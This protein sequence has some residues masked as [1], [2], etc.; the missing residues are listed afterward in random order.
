[1]KTHQF[2]EITTSVEKFSHDGRGIARINGKTTFIQGALP[3]ETVVFKYTRRKRGF[4]EGSTIDIKTSSAH[5]VEPKCAHFNVCGGCSLQHLD[6][7][8]QIQEKQTLFLDILSR[9]GHC[10]PENMLPP[11]IG[12]VWQYRHKARLS[13]RQ[14]KATSAIQLGFREKNNPARIADIQHCSVMHPKVDKELLHLR[15]LIASFDSASMI[16]QIEVAVGD[17]DVALIFRNLSPLSVDDKEKLIT[18][19]HNT[20]FRIF[21]QPGGPD[22]VELFY[23]KDAT[24]FLKYH[25]PEH[26]VS[27]SFHPTDFIQINA[28]MNRTMISQALEL[29]ALTPQDNVMDLFCGLGNFSLPIAKRCAKVIG[30]EGSDMMVERARMNAVL[31]SLSNV[32]FFSANL[33]DEGVMEMLEQHSINKLLIDPPR[34]GAMEIVKRIELLHP[35]RIVYVSCNPATLARDSDVLV[36]DK[37][38][39]LTQAGVMD[40]FP[41]T[42][43]VESIA[44]FER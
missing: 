26:G 22:T 41:H 19:A 10:S 12:A 9:I 13:V 32:T 8:M 28:G 5:R 15:Q 44:L 23:P 3:K 43:H 33:D 20:G 27:F 39:R 40:M 4:D 18:F 37:G 25:L 30:V 36:N 31:N 38:Y 16:A 21:L 7:A 35:D 29:L 24:D 11:L 17:D 14:D 42:A 1:M 6:A 2:P 34:A